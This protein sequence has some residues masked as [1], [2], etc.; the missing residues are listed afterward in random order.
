M[1][2]ILDFVVESR[3]SLEKSIKCLEIAHVYSTMKRLEEALALVDRATRYLDSIHQP[4]Q[5]PETDAEWKELKKFKDEIEKQVS[6]LLSRCVAQLYQIKGPKL[7]KIQSTLKG[8]SME[9]TDS[10]APLIARLGEFVP[11]TSKLKLIEFPP[12]MIAAPF[13]PFLVDIAFEYVSEYPS[14]KREETEKDP[15]SSSGLMGV[16]SSLWGKK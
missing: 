7:D 12:K 10:A 13:K 8:L 2:P 5:I 14:E 1:D 15:E 16:L 3:I 11:V 9:S 4:I 6:G